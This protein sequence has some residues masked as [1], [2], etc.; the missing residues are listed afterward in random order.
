MNGRFQQ[1]SL[2]E[3]LKTIDLTLDVSITVSDGEYIISK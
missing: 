1:E 2:E 3:V